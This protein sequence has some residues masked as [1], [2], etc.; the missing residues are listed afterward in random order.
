MA[1]WLLTGAPCLRMD[2]VLDDECDSHEDHRR[3][4]HAAAG[5]DALRSGDFLVVLGDFHGGA[6]P[7]MQGV[8]ANRH[9]EPGAVAAR[10]AAEVGPR[11]TLLPPRRGPV[12]MT[13]RMYP[14]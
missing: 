7:L 9:R 1:V 8:F 10:A 3:A 2:N 14:V 12:D 6:N 5:A 4:R 13:A 11:V